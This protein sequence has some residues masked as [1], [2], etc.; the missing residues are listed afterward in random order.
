MSETMK[1]NSIANINAFSNLI[2]F[3]Q[4]DSLSSL[5]TTTTTQSL[6]TGNEYNE[7]HSDSSNYSPMEKPSH[8][9]Y[10]NSETTGLSPMNNENTI[11]KNTLSKQNLERKEASNIIQADISFD[12]TNNYKFPITNKS[13]ND[14]EAEGPTDLQEKETTDESNNNTIIQESKQDTEFDNQD[15][16]SFESKDDNGKKNRNI[17]ELYKNGINIERPNKDQDQA[18]NISNEPKVSSILLPKYETI[19][20]YRKNLENSKD[21]DLLL[22]YV[23]YLLQTALEIKE[24]DALLS[25]KF[26]KESCHYLKKL[27]M[28]GYSNAQYL[29]AD[30][31]STEL[32]GHTNYKKALIL[33]QTATKHGHIESAFRTAECYEKGLGVARDS[34]KTIEFLKFAA[35]RNHSKAMFKLGIFLFNGDMGVSKD[36]KTQQNGINWLARAAARADKSCCEAPYELAKI[37]E[38]G[39]LDIIIPDL[40]YSL[41]LYIQ[42]ASLGHTKSNTKLA[43]MYEKGNSYL[44]PNKLLCVHYYTEA[45]QCKNP[46]PQAQLKLCSFYLSGIEGLLDVDLRESFLWAEKAAL[47]DF[48]KAQYTLGSFFEKGIGCQ[49]DSKLAF[50]WYAKAA[51]NNYSKA[52]ERLKKLAKELN[53]EEPDNS[54]STVDRNKNSLSVAKL[55]NNKEIST[56]EENFTHFH[57]NSSSLFSL[58]KMFNSSSSLNESIT[59][60]NYNNTI[61]DNLPKIKEINAT[62]KIQNTND[63]SKKQIIKDTEK[64]TN[65]QTFKKNQSLPSKQQWNRDLP[66]ET[67][68]ALN[69]KSMDKNV[70]FFTAKETQNSILLDESRPVTRYEDAYSQPIKMQKSKI[71][72][73]EPLEAEKFLNSKRLAK[74]FKSKKK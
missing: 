49:T 35:S 10:V 62:K 67:A 69:L 18:E 43:Q 9:S 6:V 2:N 71:N 34:R 64:T 22:E 36:Y 29:L 63:N 28:K 26:V 25:R 46:D 68:N 20:M 73:N 52:N 32:L 38:K 1:I 40:K 7:E 70:N 8:F 39:F 37:Y 45:S 66:T 19:K 15:V 54:K 56:S 12:K 24:K 16:F 53:F 4:T 11:G 13:S 58:S 48:P 41:N 27:S 57:K 44:E 65:L 72:S 60:N 23:E 47:L 74:M 51:N 61:N 50:D 17:V 33:F 21:A 59:P 31:Y 30:I 42:A 3:N 14:D 55:F 5:E